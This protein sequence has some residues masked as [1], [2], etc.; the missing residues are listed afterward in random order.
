MIGSRVRV[1]TPLVLILALCGLPQPVVSQNLLVPMDRAQGNHLRAYG[2]TYWTLEQG[3]TVEWLLNYRGGSFLLPD[4]EAVRREAAFRG[5][6]FEPIGSAQLAEIRSIIQGENMEAVPLE[7]A[8]RIAIYTPPNVPP[9]DD[10]V[11]MA[12]T[13]AEISY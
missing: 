1:I 2:L 5:V 13:Y 12:L 3:D 4:S 6:S 10:A 11:T 9:W 8:P 7:T